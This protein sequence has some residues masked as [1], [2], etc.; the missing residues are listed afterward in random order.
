MC[1]Y[2]CV[3]GC[4][5]VCQLVNDIWGLEGSNE[6]W[7]YF[8]ASSVKHYISTTII[9]IATKLDVVVNYRGRLPQLKSY[10]PLITWPTWGHVTNWKTCISTFIILM[11]TTLGRVLTPGTS[12]RTQL[13]TKVVTEFLTNLRD[14]KSSYS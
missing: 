7:V 14:N 6:I 5:C 2:M 11:T 8:S 1:V 12:F 10:K 4:V 13:I 9:P 3:F